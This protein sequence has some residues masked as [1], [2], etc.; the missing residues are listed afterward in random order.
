MNPM[1]CPKCGFP[2]MKP[3]KSGKGFFCGK[4]GN[5]YDGKKWTLCDGTRWNNPAWSGKEATPRPAQ[6]ARIKTPTTEQAIALRCLGTAP[7]ARETL[8][9]DG[10]YSSRFISANASPGTGKTT[11]ISAAAANIYSR[12]GSRDIQLWHIC[13][14]NVNARTA[15]EMKIPPMWSNISTINGFGGRIQG[16]RASNYDAKKVNAIWR[17]MI[18]NLEPDEK[19]VFGKFGSAVKNFCDRMRD[20]LL[21][22][23][24]PSSNKWKTL[25]AIA[26]ERFP[27]LAK[28]RKNMPDEITDTYIPL[29]MTELSK[30]TKR[31]DLTEQYCKPA[32]DAIIRTGWQIMPDMIFKGKDWDDEMIKHFVKLIKAMNVPQCAGVI[33]DEA[34]DLSLSQLA[35]FLAA[36]WRSGELVLV[37]DD[38]CESPYR[39]GQ[40]IFGWRGAGLSKGTLNLAGRIWQELT[41]ETPSTFELTE[42][43]RF[44]P[45]ICNAVRGL[46]STIKSAKPIGS[47][48]VHTMSSGQAF[49]RWLDIPEKPYK[50][51]WIT[52][53]NKATVQVLMDT[54][55]ARKSVS[56]R[57]NDGFINNVD[58]VLY[59]VAGWRNE[60]T[61]EYPK[62][63]KE[64]I[65]KMKEMDLSETDE[66]S[67][68]GFVLGILEEVLSNPEIL[69]Q[70]EL[71]PV[72]TVGNVRRLLAYLCDKDSQRVISTVY[73]AKGDEAN[74]CL[75][76]DIDMFNMSWNGDDMEA[77]ACRHVAATRGS[78][79]LIVCGG[80]IGFSN[81]DELDS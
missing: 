23:N 46:N 69:L 79:V 18:D 32:I 15:A 30:D 24:D 17:K 14:F 25:I 9:I 39:A 71:K 21:F 44:G 75:V 74:L 78:E 19:K 50:A 52:R 47:S 20:C 45:E 11:T 53:T 38:Y 12:V 80:L 22:T 64:A 62:T 73:R 40:A 36:T 6:W 35:L 58:R 28:A 51:L 67:I 76:S 42:T 48:E 43:H 2:N 70:A 27:A 8:C 59:D 66:N 7:D 68:E 63:L 29:I 72:P 57:G 56:L 26:E 37:G 13:A 16:F 5:Y 77:A 54:L 60:E 10:I 41:G 49:T 31:I 33:V 1:S 61:G 55:K 81:C 65:A 3:T 4:P 34:Q